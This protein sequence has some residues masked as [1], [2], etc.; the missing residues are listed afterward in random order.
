M[1][2]GGEYAIWMDKVDFDW[3]VGDKSDLGSRTRGIE[4]PSGKDKYPTQITSGWRFY[5]DRVWHNV[6]SKDIIFRGK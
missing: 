3:N 6:S 2:E 5:H 1:H 4:G